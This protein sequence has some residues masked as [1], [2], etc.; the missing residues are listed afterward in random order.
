MRR[1]AAFQMVPCVGFCSPTSTLMAV[2]LPAP[3]API[4]ATRL[5]CET[6]RLTSMMVGLSLVGYWKVTLSI[7]RI[8]LLR[9]LTPSMAPGSGK[10]NFMIS[11]LSSKYAFFSGYFS[12]NCVSVWPF[13][14]LKV[15]SLRSWKSMMCVHILSRKG[16]KCDVQMMLPPKD[17]SQSSSHLMLSTSRCPVGSSSM[18][19]SAFISCAAHSCIFI[20]QPP[21][22]EVTGLSRLAARSGPPGYPKPVFFMSSLQV[23]SDT[24]FSIL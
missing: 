6:V 7:L 17:S 3:L 9:L 22:Y 16:E 19:T 2:D 15:F 24:G 12:T 8:T 1:P 10:V 13:S 20:F 23:S 11:L 5:T 21:E 4:T 18:S 14:P